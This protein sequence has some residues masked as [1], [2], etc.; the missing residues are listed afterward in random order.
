MDLIHREVVEAGEKLSGSYVAVEEELRQFGQECQPETAGASLA[1]DGAAAWARLKRQLEELDRI[2]GHGRNLGRD[3]QETAQEASRAAAE[4]HEG[5]SSICTISGKLH[6][7]AL[8]AIV[9][10]TRLG[11]EGRTLGELSKQVNASHRECEGIVPK[12][13]TLL[14]SLDGCVSDLEGRETGGQMLDLQSLLKMEQVQAASRDMMHDMLKLVVSG[15]TKWPGAV[16][17]CKSSTPSLT[18]SPTTGRAWRSFRT[19][20]RN[21]GAA[22]SRRT[23]RPSCSPATPC[24]RSG[25]CTSR[26]RTTRLLLRT[27]RRPLRSPA[28]ALATAGDGDFGDNVELF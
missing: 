13:L 17:I 28:P 19:A 7:L 14:D 2:Q 6:F 9:Q 27:P 8:N 15:A 11:D 22:I 18:R 12:V 20:C 10:T 24:S 25:T 3:T 5:L 21:S 1:T 4:L 16:A 26:R 23:L